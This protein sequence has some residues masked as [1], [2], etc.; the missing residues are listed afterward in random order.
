MEI[1]SIV[2]LALGLSVATNVFLISKLRKR[3]NLNKYLSTQLQKFKDLSSKLR[4]IVVQREETFYKNLHD[5][6]V[7]FLDE[8]EKSYLIVF[9]GEY[10]NVVSVF[11]DTSNNI[12]K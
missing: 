7:G 12:S 6:A 3:T 4:D 11:G 1:P 8:V 2:T 10:G 5:V 9:D